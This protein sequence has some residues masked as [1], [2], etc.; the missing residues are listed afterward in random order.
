MKVEEELNFKQK[1]LEIFMRSTK[2][3]YW[4]SEWYIHIYI[5]KIFYSKMISTFISSNE[6]IKKSN[7]QIH[8]ICLSL[9]IFTSY[10][11]WHLFLFS[12]LKLLILQL[13]RTE[14]R[15]R[16]I[17]S[18]QEPIEKQDK[19]IQVIC[20]SSNYFAKS[21]GFYLEYWN[22]EYTK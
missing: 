3:K 21:C 10:S 19:W 13:M 2:V 11:G 7:L 20:N 17:S 1:P 16:Q 8:H 14:V 6:S 4:H 18:S 12:F 15:E 9:L 5:Y 22:I